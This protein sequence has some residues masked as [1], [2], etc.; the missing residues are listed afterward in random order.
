M[1]QAKG[2]RAVVPLTFIS[3]GVRR[4]E[5]WAQL[6][7]P[8]ATTPD[9]QAVR[10]RFICPPAESGNVPKYFGRYRRH[11]QLS[12]QWRPGKITG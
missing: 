5:K 4:G 8:M 11:G 9:Y 1:A 2:I 3:G 12:M 6:S 10:H 7:F